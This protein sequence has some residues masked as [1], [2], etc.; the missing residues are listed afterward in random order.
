MIWTFHLDLNQS[1]CYREAAKFVPHY[2]RFGLN[3][4]RQES[5]RDRIFLLSTLCILTSK[6]IYGLKIETN[7]IFKGRSDWDIM[8]LAKILPLRCKLNQGR[9]YSLRG[10]HKLDYTEIVLPRRM[11]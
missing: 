5:E 9:I 4:V 6:Y 1:G 8:T 2:S 11:N 3:E 7:E 10:C